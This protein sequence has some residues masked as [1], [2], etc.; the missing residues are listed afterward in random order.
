MLPANAVGVRRVAGR[1][2][3]DI[4]LCVGTF[5]AL[6]GAEYLAMMECKGNRLDAPAPATPQPKTLEGL[7][8]ARLK[9]LGAS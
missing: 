7:R 6:T 3:G 9:A 4:S 2:P 5:Q 8:A 1:K